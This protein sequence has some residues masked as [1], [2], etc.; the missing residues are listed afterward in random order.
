MKKIKEI[1]NQ[2]RVYAV[3]EVKSGNGQG[4][5][6]VAI[7]SVNGDAINMLDPGS[8][9]TNMWDTYGWEGTSRIVYYK[10]N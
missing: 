6:W 1:V 10:A 2:S 3:A 7:E 5:H 9:S 8:S 4:Q